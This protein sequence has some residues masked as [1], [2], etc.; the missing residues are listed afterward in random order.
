M[1]VIN[2]TTL[3]SLEFKERYVRHQ[4]WNYEIHREFLKRNYMPK[5]TAQLNTLKF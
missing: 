2:V 5:N 4:T 3:V 1:P